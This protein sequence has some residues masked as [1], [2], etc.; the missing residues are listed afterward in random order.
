M[1]NFIGNSKHSP[2][3]K[4]KPFVIIQ[5][6][7]VRTGTTF[8]VNLLYGFLCPNEPIH[9]VWT[10]EDPLIPFGRVSIFKTHMLDTEYFIN[11]YSHLYDFLF[12]VTERNQTLSFKHRVIKVQ[13]VEV[14]ETP[15]LSIDQIVKKMY[16]KLQP[17]IPVPLNIVAGK[18]RI[19]DMNRL[20]ETIREKPFEYIDTFYHIHGHHRHGHRDK[21]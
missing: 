18:Q 13:F 20:Y 19:L 12:I 17:A 3:P 21:S 9:G 16:L 11:K 10:E 2:I 1:Y 14:N 15:I 7:Q 6:G 4:R 5:M 8:L